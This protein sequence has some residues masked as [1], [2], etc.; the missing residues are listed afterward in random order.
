MA[1]EAFRNEPLTDFSTAENG[2]SME[3]ALARVGSQLGR[4]HDLVIGGRRVKGT[5]LFESRDP[6]D[7]DRV[8]GI[9]QKALE[10]EAKAALTAATEAF[11]SWR[12]EAAESRAEYLLKAAEVLR[13]RRFDLAALEV[14]EVGKTWAEADADVAEAIDFLEFYG[15]EMLRL[16]EPP[17]LV[18]VS[19]EDNSLEYIPLGPGVVIPPWNFP[20]A[21]TTG[22][23]SAAIVGGNTVVLKPASESPAIAAQLVDAFEEVGLPSGVLN[24]LTGPGALAGDALV[25]HPGVR[26]VAFTGSMEVGLHINSEAAK[27]REG[28][29][30]W[31]KR[32]IAE[33]GGKDAIVVAEDADLAA[34]TEGIVISAYGYTGQ[35]CSACSRAII[36]DS[37]YDEVVERLVERTEKLNVGPAMDFASDMG[38]LINQSALDKVLS[39]IEIGRVEGRLLTGGERLPGKGY[40]VQPTIFGDVQPDARLAQE[41]IFGPVLSVIPAADYDAALDIANNSIYGLTGS[42]YTLDENRIAEA[43]RKFHVGNLYINRKCTGALVGAHPFGGFNMSGT[44]SKAGGEDYLHLF[45]QAKVISEKRI[46]D[47]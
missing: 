45:T 4:E 7:P 34:A 29:Q 15:R 25:R 32:V 23:T 42:V 30:V 14:F 9:F 47:V 36:V 1:I 21:I 12:W 17:P 33:M 6:S 37:V 3:E 46:A 44:D 43:R 28:R 13:R 16:S 35:K 18:P 31:I 26:F 10:E 39:Y 19:G 27:T 41:E 40:F 11:E 20:L 2:S 22:M 24:L 5:E 38:P 8:V